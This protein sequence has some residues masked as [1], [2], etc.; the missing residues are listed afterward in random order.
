MTAEEIAQTCAEPRGLKH[1][2][3]SAKKNFLPR[4][5]LKA[6]QD[7]KFLQSI[8]KPDIEKSLTLYLQREI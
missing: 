6:S 1:G 7:H 5:R 2:G 3:K 4:R 8:I